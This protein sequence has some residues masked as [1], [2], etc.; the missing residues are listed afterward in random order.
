MAIDSIGTMVR[1]T[2]S[3]DKPR[4]DSMRTNPNT[5]I[6]IPDR[7]DPMSAIRK[8]THMAVAAH[9]DD[10]EILGYHGILSCYE[11]IDQSFF[12]VVVTDGAG[13]SRSGSYADVSDEKMK[14]LR[15]AEQETAASIGKYGALVQMGVPSFQAKAQD[16]MDLVHELAEWIR[17][18]KP[19]VLYT[20]NLADKHETHVAVAIKVILAIRT[21]PQSDRPDLVLGCEVWGDLDWLEDSEKICLDVGGNPDLAIRLLNAFPSQIQGGKRYDLATLG[22]RRANATYLDPYRIDQATEVIFAMDLT[23][24]IREEEQP[25]ASFV[26]AYLKRFQAAVQDRIVRM[27]PR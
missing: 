26:E 10:L 5:T 13:S 22:R 12:G 18:A 1:C 3:Y 17:L 21:L 24:L 11:S 19:K 20:H 8:T 7:S 2:M 27:S 6:F 9:Q 23:P 15:H 16:N 25:V 14:V 4:C